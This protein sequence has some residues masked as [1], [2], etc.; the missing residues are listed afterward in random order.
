MQ[1]NVISAEPIAKIIQVQFE[2]DEI[3][4]VYDQVFKQLRKKLEL[5]G[6][7]KGRVP[8]DLA[9]RHL[10][11][12][13]EIGVI[14]ELLKQH[15]ESI[16]NQAEVENFLDLTLVDYQFKEAE[17]V[18]LKVRIECDP[19][20]ELPN[21]K[22]GFKAIRKNYIIDP[23]SV[24]EVINR[25]QEEHA[26]VST[27]EGPVAEGH[28]VECDLQQLDE[29]NLPI[30]GRKLTDKVI[31]VGEGI[32]GGPDA[33]GLIGAR[34]GDQVHVRLPM[35]DGSKLPYQI[36]IKRIHQ[37]TLPIIDDDFVKRTYEGIGS[38][39]E[40]RQQIVASLEREYR[41]QSDNEFHNEVRNYFIENTE[42]VVPPYRV[43]RY[44][45]YLVEDYKKRQNK[46]EVD[47]EQLRHQYRPFAERTVRWYLIQRAIRE[48]ED[49]KVEEAEIEQQIKAIQAQYP[50][51]EREKVAAYFNQKD[52]RL[53]L[54]WEILEN[55]VLEH[56]KQ[57]AKEKV[58]NIHTKDLPGRG[59]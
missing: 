56:V 29:T 51:Q 24:D 31:K 40:M 26:T 22:K 41:T 49:I 13:I 10:K 16:V 18:E 17:A 21:Y 43:N 28:L 4:A 34:I 53:D 25:I 46:Q 9:R 48:R 12:D 57:Y 45:D 58:E 55:K 6:F 1:V 15:L 38:V 11:S 8:V 50:E 5:P 23:E 44:L 52:N 59:Q 3:S 14:D 20:I 42:F 33:A 19:P 2:W 47:E 27:T 39:E 36:S 30:I 54:V 37:Q 35:Q 32:F 7:R